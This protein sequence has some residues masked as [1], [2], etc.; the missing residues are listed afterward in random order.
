MLRVHLLLSLVQLALSTVDLTPSLHLDSRTAWDY[1]N[2]DRQ[3]TFFTTTVRESGY[4]GVL[5]RH[6]RGADGITLF[7]PTNAAFAATVREFGYQGDDAGALDAL[8]RVFAR[9]AANPT[10]ALYQLVG[11]H[12]IP[13]ALSVS[14]IPGSHRTYAGTTLVATKSSLRTVDASYRDPAIAQPFY[15]ANGVLYPTDRVLLPFVVDRELAAQAVNY[16]AVAKQSAVCFPARAVVQLSN[17]ALRYMQE[18]R[19]GD[20]VRVGKDEVSVVYAFTHRKRDVIAKFVQLETENNTLILSAAHMVYANGRAVR[21]DAVKMGDFLRTVGGVQSVRAVRWV[22]KYGLYAPHTLQGDIV[23]NGVVASSYTALVPRYAAHALLAPV[24]AIVRAGVAREPLGYLFYDGVPVLST[25]S[26][27]VR[28]RTEQM[29]E[30]LHIERLMSLFQR[31]CSFF[32]KICS[33]LF[34]DSN[35]LKQLRQFSIKVSRAS[36]LSWHNCYEQ[37]F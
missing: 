28:V 18:L 21:A 9:V 12:I 19:A 14:H 11:Y 1:I 32:G 2:T 29:I 25:V 3:Y 31:F 13:G 27:C 6:G 36:Q 15:P 10:N 5:S 37:D 30:L 16:N 34:V 7:A 33:S 8:K 26:A 24:R 35:S 20:V 4:I 17:G 22:W 23:V